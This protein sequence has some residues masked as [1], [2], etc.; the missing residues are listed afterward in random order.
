M[1]FFIALLDLGLL[2]PLILFILGLLKK[3]SLNGLFAILFI[4]FVEIIS[5]SS[6]RSFIAILGTPAVKNKTHHE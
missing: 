4:M 5:M 3:F 1:I 6:I 2:V